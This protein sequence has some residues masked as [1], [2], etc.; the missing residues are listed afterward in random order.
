MSVG[1]KPNTSSAAVQVATKAYNGV[2][3]PIYA[4]G[5]ESV[6]NNTTTALNNGQTFTGEWED[7][8]Q[9]STVT[10]AVKTDQD[11]Q[12]TVQFSPDGTNADST[13]TRYYRTAKIEAPHNFTITRRYCRVTFT[14]N[15]GSNQTYLRLQTLY[16]AR[17]QLNAPCDSTLAP[18]FDA[19]VTR[20]TDY[21][22]EVALGRRQGAALWNKFGKNDDVD[23]GTE[24]VA[25]FGGA[26]SIFTSG[27]TFTLV[28]DSAA[29]DDGGTG[30]NSVVVYG[31]DSNWD[32][33]IEVVTLD[34]TTPVA[35]T[36]SWLSY[37]NRIA[38]NLCGTGQTNAGTITCTRTTGGATVG[39]MDPGEGVTQQ[40]IFTVPQSHQFLAEYLKLN[41][42]R[43]TSG[44][45]PQVTFT[46][47]VY[48]AVNNGK[49]EVYSHL[50]DTD[51]EV[52]HSENPRLQFPIG[53]KSIIW[54]E[55]TTTQDNT[56]AK[57]R[58][59]GVLHEDVDH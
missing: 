4:T 8:S 23:I 43:I 18:D 10:V 11:G 31:V 27:S 13:L 44:T 15:S 33:A 26:M 25:N 30:C 55:A 20:P 24:V 16:G 1:V 22:T 39:R 17:P 47:W 58:L 14:N 5:V 41:S 32:E 46:V 28:S 3:Y 40:V 57:C 6:G 19:I 37:P 42:A 12:F 48:S 51:I 2:E 29:D 36:T 52:A 7:V 59:S 56:V 54:V 45:N 38:M 50:M 35:T 49:Q 34:G 9:F 21:K 53:E